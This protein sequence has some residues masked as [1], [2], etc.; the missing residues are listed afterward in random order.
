MNQHMGFMVHGSWFMFYGSWSMVQVLGVGSWGV[1]FPQSA[2]RSSRAAFRFP[3]KVWEL[4][5][6]NQHADSEP[7][8]FMVHGLWFTFYGSWFMVHDLWLMVDGLGFGLGKLGCRV[9]QSA[10]RSYHAAFRSPVEVW[11]CRA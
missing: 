11:E 1:G 2:S 9:F 3:V 6:Q 7:M 8:G 10:W 5:A 4:R